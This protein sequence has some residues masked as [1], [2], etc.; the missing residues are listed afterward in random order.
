[1]HEFARR[2]VSLATHTLRHGQRWDNFQASCECTSENHDAHFWNSDL[3]S[4]HGGYDTY[5]QSST[6]DRYDV[7]WN[8][9]SV[10]YRGNICSNIEVNAINIDHLTRETLK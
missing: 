6:A 8:T 3:W 4:I 1:M 9:S 10:H 2:N 7:H 5:I